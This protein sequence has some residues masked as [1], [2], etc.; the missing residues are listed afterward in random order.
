[1]YDNIQLSGGSR[2]FAGFNKRINKELEQL[3]YQ[4]VHTISSPFERTNQAR[5]G[6]SM[7]ASLSTFQ[8]MW[9]SKQEYNECGPS[10]VHRK[11][12]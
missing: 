12:L 4:K 2:L 1:M 7:L 10:M 9:I 6:G 3:A 8:S 5:S 11:C